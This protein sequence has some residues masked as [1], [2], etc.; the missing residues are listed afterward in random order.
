MAASITSAKTDRR[1]IPEMGVDGETKFS[2]FGV[3]TERIDGKSQREPTASSVSGLWQQQLLL[4]KFLVGEASLT[5][6]G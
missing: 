2:L 1:G 6:N 5:K 3:K 4:P